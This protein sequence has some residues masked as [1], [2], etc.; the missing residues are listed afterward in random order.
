L[1]LSVIP[2][3]RIKLSEAKTTIEQIKLA[4]SKWRQFAEGAELTRREQEIMES[5]FG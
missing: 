1:A 2:Y 3:F 4:I 5:A